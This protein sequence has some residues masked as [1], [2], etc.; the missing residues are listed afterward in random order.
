MAID[1]RRLSEAQVDEVLDEHALGK[2]LAARRARREQAARLAEAARPAPGDSDW[3]VMVTSPRAEESVDKL[4]DLARIERWLPRKKDARQRRGCRPVASR[5]AV[6]VPAFPG[7]LFVRVMPSVRAFAGLVS[8]DH[9]EGLIGNAEGRPF[10]VRDREVSQL[11]KF[12]DK[13]EL[14]RTVEAVRLAKGDRV[15]VEEGPFAGHQGEVQWI[16][17]AQ[18]GYA[19]TAHVRVL[20]ALFGGVAP[21]TLQLDQIVKSE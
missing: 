9:V 8:L 21:V 18:A 16:R 17:E 1:I 7:Y 14:D 11:R 15:R 2:A 12:V 10:P 20:M 6:L 13:G 3:F 19:G 5:E 4:L